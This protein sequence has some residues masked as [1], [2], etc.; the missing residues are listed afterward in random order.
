MTVDAQIPVHLLNEQL[1]RAGFEVSWPGCWHCLAQDLYQGEPLPPRPSV[2]DSAL[3]RRVWGADAR[4]GRALLRAAAGWV[5]APHDDE[6]FHRALAVWDHGHPEATTLDGWHCVAYDLGGFGR[7]RRRAEIAW[8]RDCARPVW[9]AGARY[10]PEDAPEPWRL[11]WP[12]IPEG[13]T[14]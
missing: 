11:V 3:L 14:R 2:Y 8:C 7:G 1:T 10:L 13:A 6:D 9:A 5:A 4:L 12:A